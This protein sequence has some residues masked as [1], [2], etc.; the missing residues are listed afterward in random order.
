MTGSTRSKSELSEK[1]ENISWIA[2]KVPFD[3]IYHAP[4]GKYFTLSKFGGEQMS[5]SVQSRVKNSVLSPPFSPCLY[6]QVFD[7]DRGHQDPGSNFQ[8]DQQDFLNCIGLYSPFGLI[9]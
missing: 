9:V 4:I 5:E 8:T 7:K 2:N 3:G 6:F 1:D